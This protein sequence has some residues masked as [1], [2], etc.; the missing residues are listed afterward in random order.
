MP[1]PL[2]A[3]ELASAQDEA[4]RGEMIEY[5]L[6]PPG[7]QDFEGRTILSEEESEPLGPYVVADSR[8]NHGTLSDEEVFAYVLEMHGEPPLMIV[9]GTWWNGEEEEDDA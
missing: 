1:T 4:T 2:E 6:R 7:R 9:R 5:W 8:C 3:A